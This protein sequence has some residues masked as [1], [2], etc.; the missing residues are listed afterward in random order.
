MNQQNM[1]M[2][3]YL[4]IQQKLINEIK[5]IANFVISKKHVR[6]NCIM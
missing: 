3:I 4:Y 5:E 1:E 6:V 2:Y